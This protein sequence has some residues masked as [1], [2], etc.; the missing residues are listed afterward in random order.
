MPTNDLQKAVARAIHADHTQDAPML[1]DWDQLSQFDQSIRRSQA[2]AAIAAVL[3]HLIAEAEKSGMSA[4]SNFS[5]WYF[6]GEPQFGDNPNPPDLA[7][8]LRSF[9]EAG[10]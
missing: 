7:D 10:E 9:R 1:P 2:D 8:W 5:G 4:M 6:E 3:E